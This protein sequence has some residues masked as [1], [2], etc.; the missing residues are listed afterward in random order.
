MMV[1]I[2]VIEIYPPMNK[3]RRGVTTVILLQQPRDLEST[4]FWGWLDVG[5]LV[6]LAVFR[7]V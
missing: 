1:F 5:A 3:N 4:R 6:S 7:G 2:I